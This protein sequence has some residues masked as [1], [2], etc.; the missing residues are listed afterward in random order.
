MVNRS[1]ESQPI[2]RNFDREKTVLQETGTVTLFPDYTLRD[3]MD[4]VLDLGIDPNE[5]RFSAF[6]ITV[7]EADS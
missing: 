1:R 7:F 3:I 6:S 4:I 2:A 5:V